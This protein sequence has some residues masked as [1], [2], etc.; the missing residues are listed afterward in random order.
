MLALAVVNQKGGVGKTTVTLG[1]AAA[2]SLTG[3]RVLV[4]DLDPQANATTGLG[5]FDPP[6]TV[7]HVLAEDRP[8]S[9]ADIL[10]P[11]GWPAIV[12]TPP[13]VAPSSPSLAN[14]EPQL[15]TDPVGAQDRLQVALEGTPHD[16]VLID[17]PPSLGL[18]TVNGLFAA[19]QALI[20]TAPSAW[21][22]D[23]VAQVLTTIDRVGRRRPGGLPVAGICVNNV[24]RTRDAS[25]WFEQIQQDHADHILAP[26]RQRAAIAEAGAQS[27]PVHALGNR[28]GA[29]EAA[30]EFAALLRAILARTS[31]TA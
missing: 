24:G 1:L 26:I 14:R 23:G 10:V 2:A 16:L 29:P 7:D 25:Y 17:C 15:A 13:D 28:A 11:A 22:S 31:A 9:I 30:D 20:V 3:Q 18:L 5:V 8:G 6:H 12:G 27:L 21:A 19:D 4:V